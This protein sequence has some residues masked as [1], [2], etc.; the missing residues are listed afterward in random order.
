MR[1]LL[2]LTLAGG[3]AAP[4]TGGFAQTAA[5]TNRAGANQSSSASETLNPSLANG[6]P[7]I[8]AQTPSDQS[9][10][11]AKAA[12]T[13]DRANANASLPVVPSDWGG[14]AKAW[15][16]HTKACSA[17]YKG[18]DAATDQYPMRGGAMTKCTL[19]MGKAQ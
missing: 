18:Y 5:Q 3:L 14:D 15:A 13:G 2:T 9:A 19:A 17:K 12:T 7:P 6:A 4:L 10:A 8:P 1:I 16:A 11:S